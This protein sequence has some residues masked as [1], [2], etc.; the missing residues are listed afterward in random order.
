MSSTGIATRSYLEPEAEALGR[1]SIIR[2]IDAQTGSERLANAIRKLFAK[3][4]VE[5]EL[6]PGAGQKLLPAG[7]GGWGK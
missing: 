2:D 1:S 6:Q 7:W 5:N 3:F 4:E